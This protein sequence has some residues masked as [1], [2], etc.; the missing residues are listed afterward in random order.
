MSAS[1]AIKDAEKKKSHNNE[2]TV[3]PKYNA[4]IPEFIHG[5]YAKVVTM[6]A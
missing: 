3:L 6:D 5:M 2:H 4:I 1:Y